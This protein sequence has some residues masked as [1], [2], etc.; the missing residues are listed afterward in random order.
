[1]RA[2]ERVLAWLRSAHETSDYTTS[3]LHRRRWCSPPPDIIDGAPRHHALAR[4]R[5]AGTTRR[6]GLTVAERVVRARQGRHREQAC[7]RGIDMALR[8]RGDGSP[9]TSVAQSDS[10]LRSSTTPS[11]RST[12]GSPSTKRRRARRRPVITRG[13][14]G[15]CA[16]P[17]RPSLDQA[18][19]AAVGEHL[20]AGLARG[21]VGDLVALVAHPAQR[22]AAARA[23]RAVARR[24][25]RSARRASAATSPPVRAA[26]ALEAVGASRRAPRRAGAAAASSS[27]DASD[28]YGESCARHSASS[29]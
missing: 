12:V 19:H 10:A 2:D 25:P 22:L 28:A 21:A 8:A 26:L 11:H 20:A 9:A 6:D 24:A 18:R 4:G 27:S 17:D 3:V 7:R 16:R 5:R 14:A 23:R 29:A 1:M 13:R 15:S